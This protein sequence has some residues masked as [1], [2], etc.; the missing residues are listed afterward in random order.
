MAKTRSQAPGNQPVTDARRPKRKGVATPAG[1]LDSPDHVLNLQF[2]S[3]APTKPAGNKSKSRFSKIPSTHKKSKAPSK[4]APEIAILST[5]LL[6]EIFK[7]CDQKERHQVLPLVCKHWSEVLRAPSAAWESLLVYTYDELTVGVEEFM[8]ALSYSK[9]LK[10][11]KPRAKGIT[12]LT[13]ENNVFEEAP[14]EPVA[15]AESSFHAILNAVAPTLKTLQIRPEYGCFGIPL[16]WNILKDI[17]A[18]ARTLTTLELYL[19]DD[20]KLTPEHVEDI[21]VFKKLEHL[22]LRWMPFW[23][24]DSMNGRVLMEVPTNA[25]TSTIST[26]P[27]LPPNLFDLK[28]LKTLHLDSEWLNGRFPKDLQRL[29]HLNELRLENQNITKLDFIPRTLKKLSLRGSNHGPSIMLHGLGQ[30]LSTAV[31]GTFLE[32]LDLAKCNLRKFNFVSEDHKYE[33]SAVAAIQKLDLS[34]NNLGPLPEMNLIDDMLNLRSLDLCS[35][36]LSVL[37]ESMVINLENLEF[38]NL[39]RNNLVDLPR[40]VASMRRLRHIYLSENHFPA[41]PEVLKKMGSLQWIDLSRCACLEI[42]K[43]ISEWLVDDT[44]N[45]IK[46]NV[47]KY[48]RFQNSSILWL[49]EAVKN[50]ILV[51]RSDVLTYKC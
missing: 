7:L 30:W 6:I 24:D 22:K 26:A 8:P 35:C 32:E 29:K 50:L 15:V 23:D 17:A 49:E 14:V 41:I 42:S 3:A 5:A 46:V 40:E 21:K 39:S 4:P 13:F 19:V 18:A 2:D 12:D 36:G 47:S 38:L 33:V 45:L 48:E 51:G 16:R 1:T 31:D 9:L 44:K 25:G 27:M 10:W 11:I 28:H 43:S 37:P 34:Y 20:G